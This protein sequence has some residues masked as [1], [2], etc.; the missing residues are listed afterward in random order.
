MKGKT[1]EGFSDILKPNNTV[2]SGLHLSNPLH[3]LKQN[4]ELLQENSTLNNENLTSVDPSV[5]DEFKIPD[6]HNLSLEDENNEI[7]FDIESESP[8]K[9]EKVSNSKGK[10][11]LLLI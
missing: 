4:S 1:N 11:I 7:P 10:I 2:T 3:M 9:N 5:W 6:S 8:I